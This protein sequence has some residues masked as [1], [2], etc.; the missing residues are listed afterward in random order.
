[1]VDK[2]LNPEGY[3]P[4]SD[5]QRWNQSVYF[6]FYDPTNKIGCFIRIGLLENLGEANNWFVF[7]KDGKPLFTRMNMNLPYTDQRI[8]TG[9][10]VA[11][12]TIKALEPM[13]RVQITYDKPDFKVD[14]IWDAILPLVDAIHLSDAGADDGF[15]KELMHVHLEGVCRVTGKITLADGEI[16]E[17]DGKGFRDVAV[18]P[19]N[20]DFMS[21][22]RLTWP[23]FD[24]G[25]AI[26][27]THGISVKNEDAYVKMIGKG[28]KWSGVK[29]IEDKNIYEDDGMTLKEMQWRVVDDDGQVYSYTGKRLF[30]WNFPLD[31]YICL[32][33][34]MEYTRDDGVKGY[35]LGECGFRFP[36]AGNG[37]DA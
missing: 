28:G 13:K 6:N 4:A 33:H 24:D 17:I 23:I 2:E 16:I 26:V 14:L 25:V 35:G 8:D 1:M 7:F 18:G 29:S 12:C 22:Y 19:R 27:A 30:H 36:W 32:E 20:W 3:C 15:F 37:E 9:L 10:S 31:T 21:H 5:H 34:M 11:G